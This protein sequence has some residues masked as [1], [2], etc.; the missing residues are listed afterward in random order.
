MDKIMNRLKTHFGN[1]ERFGYSLIIVNVVFL[2]ALALFLTK[3]PQGHSSLL[4]RVF[5]NWSAYI[6]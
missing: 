2:V 4:A 1:E 3:S 5:G 6:I